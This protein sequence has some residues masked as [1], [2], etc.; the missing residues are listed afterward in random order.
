LAGL[1]GKSPVDRP[2]YHFFVAADA[3]GKLLAGAR[4]WYRGTLKVDVIN[5]PPLPLRLMNRIFHLV[6]PDYV[7]RDISINSLW[8]VP[9]HLHVAQYLWE[10]MR[11]LC[12]ERGTTLVIGF[13]PRN[14]ARNAV[15]LKPWHQPRPQIA[16]AFRGPAPMD[17]NRLLYSLDR[18]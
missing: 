13:D 12:R 14:P 9:D 8:H 16:L 11:W 5:H 2:I 6:P 17:R 7:I 1:A 4:A 10:S 3:S 18:V 15:K